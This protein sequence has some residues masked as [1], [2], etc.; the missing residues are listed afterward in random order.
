MTILQRMQQQLVS[1]LGLV[2]INQWFHQNNNKFQNILFYS[3]INIDKMI[4]KFL[5]NGF[6][7]NIK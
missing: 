5:F 1:L 4:K 7:L 6:K 2:A 3:I